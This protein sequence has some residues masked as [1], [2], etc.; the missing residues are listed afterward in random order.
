MVTGGC[1]AP[2][3]VSSQLVAGLYRLGSLLEDACG[4]GGAGRDGIVMFLLIWQQ[5]GYC[6]DDDGVDDDDEGNPTTHSCNSN[7][8]TVSRGASAVPFWHPRVNRGRATTPK[9]LAAAD[10]F[11][12]HFSGKRKK[13]LLDHGKLA[14]CCSS[15]P[16]HQIFEIISTRNK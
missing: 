7:E 14:S 13:L 3:G 16:L 8:R 5:T 9:R 11:L 2:N 12:F 15:N 1:A 10:C 4:G 6:D